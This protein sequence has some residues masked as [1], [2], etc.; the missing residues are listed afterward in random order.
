MCY[1][2][3]MA[4]ISIYRLVNFVNCKL[5]DYSITSVVWERCIAGFTVSSLVF[6]FKIDLQL[7]YSPN[8]FHATKSTKNYCYSNYL[9][10]LFQKFYC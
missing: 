5:Q 8:N 3:I 4:I 10:L 6:E 7:F 9:Q 1:Y 2:V